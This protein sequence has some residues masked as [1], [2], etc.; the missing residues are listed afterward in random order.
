MTHFGTDGEV[1]RVHTA[2]DPFLGTVDDPALTVF[3]LGSGSPDSSDIGTSK[4]LGDSE[5]DDLGI[6]GN[7]IS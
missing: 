7:L 2:R 3:A 6:S 1:V 5:R 4:R